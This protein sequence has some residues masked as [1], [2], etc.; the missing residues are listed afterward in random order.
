MTVQN[1]GDLERALR[2]VGGLTAIAAVRYAPR[3]VQFPLGL[4]AI[5]T[6]LSGVTGWCP[7]Y[8]AAGLTS[9]GGSLDHPKER[10]R[11]TWLAH[12]EGGRDQAPCPLTPTA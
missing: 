12:T 10:V 8:A 11:D 3:A 2:L 4:M 7:T 5:S 9:R 1:L 6:V